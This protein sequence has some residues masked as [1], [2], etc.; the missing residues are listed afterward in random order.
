MLS[1]TRTSAGRPLLLPSNFRV[2]SLMWVVAFVLYLP[3]A[4][5]GWVIDAA[6][7]LYNVRHLPFWDYINNS[8]SH[9]HSLYQSTQFITWV[10]YKMFGANPYCWHACMVT[11]HALN[12]YLLFLFF[13]DLLRDASVVRGYGIAIAGAMLFL[14]APYAAEVVIWEAS[15]HYLTGFLFLLAILRLVQFFQH[16]Q[17]RAY[18]LWAAGL[19]VCATYSLE[20]FYLIPLFVGS[21]AVFYRVTLRYDRAVFQKTVTYFLLP[22]VVLF[23]VHIIIYLAV[24]GFHMPHVPDAAVG[25]SIIFFSKP[26]KYV[27]HIL[28]EGR[29]FPIDIRQR[30]YRIL[31]M[32]GVVVS[33][34]LVTVI[35][36][37]GLW[38]RFKR[39][40]SM[41]L[42]LLLV[43]WC[44]LTL[45]I[46]L[47]LAFP[48][49]LLDFYDRYTYF[50][51]GFFYMLLCLL[52]GVLIKKT[53]IIRLVFCSY[54]MVNIF[55]AIKMVFLW[56]H[57]TYV[58]NQLLGNFPDPAGKTVI[59]LNLPENMQGVPM[60]GA[61]ADGSYK[62]MRLL[63]TG[64]SVATRVYDAAS[65][66]TLS[67]NDGAHVTVVDDST[68]HVTMNQW[69]TWWWYEGHGGISYEN[70]EYRLK[71]IDQG[72]WY[73]LTLKHP[74]DRY[75]LLFEVNAA[76]KEV[77][78]TRK[79][80]D[81]F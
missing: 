67:I 76:W 58:D 66:N 34:Y 23:G 9:V 30:I 62:A 31:E 2:F 32:K 60:I 54:L 52:G 38:L 59:L 39:S 14:V 41:Q 40:Y 49:I 11:L 28:V 19:F 37:S 70:D 8:Q 51:S 77:D 48:E 68:V 21:L 24:Y 73:Q 6:G 13:K 15:F 5:A 81:Q 57:A 53:A 61:Q 12:A 17:L 55:F 63:L 74:A 27:F 20:V 43:I 4:K 64:D 1:I 18:S 35:A 75:L 65:F 36:I 50:F 46:L 80:Q 69:G 10:L 26:L 79:N 45:A 7:W 78:M 72:H 25:S 42:A 22:Q 29:F 3:A 44:L 47:P 16:R 56:K 33:F 71:M